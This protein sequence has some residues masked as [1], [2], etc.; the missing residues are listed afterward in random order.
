MQKL[1]FL[2]AIACAV[3]LASCGGGTAAPEHFGSDSTP[4]ATG[5]SA[6]P[7]SNQILS[8]LA[9]SPVPA[10][11]DPLVWRLLNAHLA[12]QLEQLPGKGLSSAPATAGSRIQLELNPTTRTFTW[13]YRLH[14]DYD[15]NGEVGPSDITALARQLGKVS[16]GGA[17]PLESIEWVVDGDNNGEI[18]INDVTPIGQNWLRKVTAYNLY[19]SMDF[20][21]YPVSPTAANGSGAVFVASVPF[22]A[23]TGDPATERLNFSLAQPAVEPGRFYWV[24]PIDGASLGTSSNVSSLNGLPG[25]VAPVA[26]FKLSAPSA[27]ALFQLN[28]DASES[29][30]PDGLQ[31]GGAGIMHFEWDFNGDGVYDQ[32]TLTPFTS[33]VYYAPG[34]YH[35]RLR[36][37]DAGAAFSTS[38]ELVF[39]VP[40]DGGTGTNVAPSADLTATP[41]TGQLPLNVLFDAS[42]T[43]D[44]APLS[45]LN[46]AWDFGT[47]AFDYDSGNFPAAAF[48]FTSA[49]VYTVRVR[50]TDAA[51]LS[52]IDAV[53]ITVTAAGPSAGAP[54]A[55][56]TVSPASGAPPL[57]VEFDFSGS[58]DADGSIAKYELDF[59]GNGIYDATYTSTAKVQH[60]YTAAGNYNATLR[61]TD[62]EGKT[63]TLQVEIRVGTPPNEN[64]DCILR[65]VQLH[66]HWGRRYKFDASDCSDTDGWVVKY[67]WDFNGDGIWDTDSGCD[68]VVKHTY[69]QAGTFTPRVRATDNCGA[70][71]TCSGTP[72]VLGPWNPDGGC[73][74]GGSGSNDNGSGGHTSH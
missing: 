19:S 13:R 62:N 63:A 48:T 35:V 72:I 47:G 74:C 33:N 65:V 17:F 23:A 26:K 25:N 43:T 14:G 53:T 6:S 11:V 34:N 46:Y 28:F 30:D 20:A 49:G 51:G 3:S 32:S 31:S 52:S 24:R 71:S 18:N 57:L 10:D 38:D 56:F 68:P 60:S 22:S 5:D 59:D 45:G 37:M 73:G 64:P 8:D 4:T 55:S 39:P 54:T 9:T 36:V 2:A 15:Q 12:E 7:T 42:N 44:D 27:D 16:A 21:D 70:T 69:W 41:G 50:A 61:V 29:Y 1:L 66:G 67:E 40:Q 58:R